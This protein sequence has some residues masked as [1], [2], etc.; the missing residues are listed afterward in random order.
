[1]KQPFLIVGLFLVALFGAL[2]QLPEQHPPDL[3][4]PMSAGSVE[5]PDA[6]R[7]WN[8]ERLHDPATGQIPEDIRSKEL[9]FARHLPR[10]AAAKSLN[11][12]QHGPRNRGG[13]TRAFRVDIT[14]SDVLVAG[15]ATGGIFRST[16]AGASWTKTSTPMDIQNT[17]CLAQDIR[18]GHEQTWYCGTGENYGVVSGTSFEALLPGDG[19]FKSTDGGQSWTIL[20]STLSGDAPVFERKGAFKHVNSIVVDPVRQDSDIVVAAIFDGLVRS[21]D[22]GLTWRTVLGIDTTSTA[23]SL[24][25]EVRVSPTGVYYAAIG[26]TAPW[27]GV[28]RS[29]DGLNWTNIGSVY[30]SGAARSVIAIDPQDE[31][32]VWFFAETPG[33]GVHGHSL[34]RYTYVSG[35]GTGT[36]GVWSNRTANLPN[37]SCTGYFDFDFGYINSQTSYDM[38]IAVHPTDSNTVFIGGTSV[39]RS[40]DGWSTPESYRWVGGYQC[41]TAD[42]KNYVWPNHHP[43]QHWLE[44]ANNDPARL[45]STNDG[46]VHVTTDPMADSIQWTVLNDRYY[47]S[48]FYTVAIEEGAATSPF[49]IGGMQDNGTY[50]C[51][52]ADPDQPWATVGG[53]DGAY[54]AIPEGRPFMLASTQLGK[55][56]KAEVDDAGVVGQF[57]RI[58]PEVTGS[59]NFINQFVL[60]PVSSNQVYWCAGTKLYRNTD[61]AGIPFTNDYYNTEETNWELIAAVSSSPRLTALDISLAQP[62]ALWYGTTNGRVYR[63]D[64]LQGTPVRTLLDSDE[65]PNGSYI[66]CVAPN[67]YDASEW[68]VTFSNYGVRSVFLT[69]DSGATWT[70]VS[71]NIEE[72][73]DGSG[74]GP[75]VFWATIYPTYD[76]ANNRYFI[77]TS[78]GLYSTALLDGDNTVWEQEGADLIGNVPIN[79]MAARGSDGLVAVG[80]HGSGVF[81]AHLPAAPIGISE[82]GALSTSHAWPNPTTDLVNIT[83]YLPNAGEVDALVYDL[84]G[85]AVFR[86]KLGTRPA[87]NS[88]FTWDV[89][90]GARIAAGT[91]FVRLSSGDVSRLERVVVR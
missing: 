66:S 33:V 27:R 79:M 65:W 82:A 24:Y 19:I 91:Y 2:R 25:T 16:D 22:G 74:N 57:E 26:R 18:A 28:Y 62:D 10:R 64:S 7:A 47:T 75:A 13:R 80:T 8:E 49:I 32:R 87:G 60:D 3:G 56:F 5:D 46:G 44:F 69:T 40:T 1:M 77:G 55:L 67:D 12:T 42:P 38:C 48:Q 17:S 83:Y 63:V 70:S 61:L 41:D 31:D 14:N 89:R 71:G 39:Y 54:C 59:Y 9:A 50:L 30:P 53:G 51:T 73:A 34:L 29:T 52:S 43:D 36:G 15:S 76:G 6:L 23:T 68:L 86:R 11:W 4:G 20:P 78:T 90:A 85:R 58:D 84:N 81:T 21:N 72:N 35:D 45:Y 88:L 37:G